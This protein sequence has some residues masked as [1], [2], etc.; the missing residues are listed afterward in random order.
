MAWVYI[1]LYYNNVREI[2]VK[3]ITTY[4]KKVK[5]LLEYLVHLIG[6]I[7]MTII[8][9]HINIGMINQNANLI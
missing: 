9:F 5:R 6:F 4:K 7:S 2:N 3:L 8:A 1:K